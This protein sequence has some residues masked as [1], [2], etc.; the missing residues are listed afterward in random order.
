MEMRS[1]NKVLIRATALCLIT[2]FALIVGGCSSDNEESTATGALKK[3]EY[4]ARYREFDDKVATASD[5]EQLILIR[6]ISQAPDFPAELE[7]D[8]TLV[9]TGYEDALDGKNVTDNE[10]QFKEASTR[11]SRHAIDNCELLQSN[12]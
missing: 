5:E 2:V 6:A 8:Y 11:M 3:T 9:I 1:F 12:R 7:A 4:C 10:D